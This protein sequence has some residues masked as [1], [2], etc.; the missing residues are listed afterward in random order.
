MPTT[1]KESFYY[2]LMMCAGMVV[3]MTFY[4]LIINDLIGEI[5]LKGILIQLLLGFIVAFILE[6]FIVG[7]VAQKL[8]LSLP[9]D[10]SKKLFVILW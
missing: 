4:N 10:K 7:P 8:A 5:P 3:V 1:K 9:Y 2:G 6:S